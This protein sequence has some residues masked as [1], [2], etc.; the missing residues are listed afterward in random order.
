MVCEIVPRGPFHCQAKQRLP[1]ARLSRLCA[2]NPTPAAYCRQD[3]R[4]GVDRQPQGDRI[5]CH[6]CVFALEI[7]SRVMQVTVTMVNIVSLAKKMLSG[8]YRDF[9]E[10]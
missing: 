6:I 3:Q 1:C 5:R 8:R 2:G 4:V 10:F 7:A 9:H